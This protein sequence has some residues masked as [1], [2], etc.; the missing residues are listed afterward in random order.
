MLLKVIQG[1]R[2]TIFL[3][4]FHRNNTTIGYHFPRHDRE[5]V[6]CETQ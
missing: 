4:V 3:S 5:H 2:H 6:S 1:Y